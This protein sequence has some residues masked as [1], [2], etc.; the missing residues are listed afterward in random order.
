MRVK[1]RCPPLPPEP[2]HHF[3]ARRIWQTLF[4][5]GVLLIFNHTLSWHPL[6]ASVP[7]AKVSSTVQFDNI[8]QAAGIHFV[9][10]KGSRGTSTILEEAGP[11]GCVGDYD[12]DR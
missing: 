4:A 10:Y 12:G 3:S 8:T 6:Q 1:K 9:H 5:L 7:Q 2:W 11:G